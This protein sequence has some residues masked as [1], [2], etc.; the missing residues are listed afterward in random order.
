[1]SNSFYPSKLLL[2]G[3]HTVL[4]GSQ[5]LALPLERY[6]GIWKYSEDKSLQYDLPKFADYL[7]NLSQNKEISLDT[8]GLIQAL[9]QGLY[10]DSNI[11]R[12]YGTGSSGALVAAVYDMF[13]LNKT[14]DL[15]EL[16]AILGKMESYFHGASSGF[17]PLICYVQ[18]PV[19]I[20]KDKKIET[21][22]VSKNDLHLFLIDT[23]IPRKGEHLIKIFGD[24][25]KTPQ[26]RALISEYF[27]PDIDD[28]IAAYLGNIPD[29]LF[30]SVHKISLF[31]YR[32][33]P[34]AVPLA[35][36]NIWLEGLSSDMYK[37]KL[38]GSG[39]GGFILGF[40]KNLE[41]TQKTM[42]KSGF[43]IIPL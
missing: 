7:H 40:C 1:M 5:A 24:R 26:Y 32:H 21:I 14:E 15:V 38:C 34:E 33:F 9:S 37:L 10:F 20:K 19:L 31:Q 43:H 17:D 39:G 27:V 35:F 2:F 11:P 25:A 36:K 6:G 23:H 13:C 28:A 4:L 29:I 22:T 18:K 41:N 30:D 16:K 8:K 42:L 3:E 12:G